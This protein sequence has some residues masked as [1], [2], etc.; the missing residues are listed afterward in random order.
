LQHH[1]FWQT[2]GARIAQEGARREQLDAAFA[3]WKRQKRARFTLGTLKRWKQTASYISRQS[4]AATA[5]AHYCGV[6]DRFLP[7][8]RDV[9]EAVIRYEDEI[10]T[11][12]SDRRL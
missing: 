3:E 10:N 5:L 12:T 4:N 6:D 2:E 8:E 7:L 1:Q 11:Q 9:I